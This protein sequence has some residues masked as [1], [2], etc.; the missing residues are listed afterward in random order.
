MIAFDR[1]T[2]PYGTHICTSVNETDTG[3]KLAIFTYSDMFVPFV[4]HSGLPKQRMMHDT[5]KI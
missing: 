3:K 4:V 2:A 1:V 5:C